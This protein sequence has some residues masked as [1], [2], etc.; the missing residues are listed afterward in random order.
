MDQLKREEAMKDT[1]PATR[2]A[3]VEGSVYARGLMDLGHFTELTLAT[4]IQGAINAG[5]DEGRRQAA[6]QLRLMVLELLLDDNK[7][8]GDCA[9]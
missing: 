8:G 4:H 9:A 5:I 1:V 3:S 2:P 7:W 6:C